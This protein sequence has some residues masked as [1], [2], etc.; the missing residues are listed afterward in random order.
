MMDSLE[1]ATRPSYLGDSVGV[2][3]FVSASDFGTI[4]PYL[5]A[6]LAKLRRVRIQRR[7]FAIA[8]LLSDICAGFFGVLMG[9]MF[10]EGGVNIASASATLAAALP[11]YM[12]AALQ[13]GAHSPSL[14]HKAS[15]SIQRSVLAFIATAAIFFLGVFFIEIGDAVSR[16][17]VAQTMLACLFLGIAGRLAISLRAQKVLSPKPWADLCIYDDVPLKGASRTGAITSKEAGLVLNFSEQM[18]VERLGLVARGMD[19]IIVHCSPVRREAWSRALKC[20]DIRSEIVVPELTE[21]MPLDIRYRAGQVS[22]VLANGPLR[23]HQHVSKKLFDRIFAVVALIL[24]APLLVTIAI[25]IKLDSKGPVFF[26]QDRIGLGNRRFKIWKFRSMRAEKTD[27]H[28]TVSASRDDD[29]ITRVGRFLRGTSLDELPQILNVLFGQMS[30]VGP[31]PHAVGSKA[32]EALFWDIDQRYWYRHSIRPGI[33]GLAQIRGLRGA[34]HKRIDL[35]KRLHADLEYVANWSLLGDIRIIFQTF[36]VLF[37]K[38][39]Y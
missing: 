37:H 16:L 6:K 38:N 13:T 5:E 32:E 8:L 17:Y 14:A 12:L 10:R 30:V 25:A 28:G 23:W 4:S 33:T 20:V 29:R 2:S 31:R 3:S 27:H 21:M 35:E 19:R 22:L 34:T 11:V 18:M 36:A 1:T 24:L 15:T 9:Q 7:M 26:R 39:A